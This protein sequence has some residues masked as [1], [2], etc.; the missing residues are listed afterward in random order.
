MSTSLSPELSF[1][2]IQSRNDPKIKFL[3]TFSKGNTILPFK[4]LLD[5]TDYTKKRMKIDIVNKDKTALDGQVY[6]YCS[7]DE[8][9]NLSAREFLEL[10]SIESTKIEE[11]DEDEEE[12]EEDEEDKARKEE[13]E[14]YYRRSLRRWDDY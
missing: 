4:T 9:I 8:I 7:N 3:Y 12:D 6:L 13:E 1:K 5:L 10:R 2:Y 14:E 11:K